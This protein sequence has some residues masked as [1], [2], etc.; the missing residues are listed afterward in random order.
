MPYTGGIY[1]AALEFTERHISESGDISLK[2]KSLVNL[3]NK[4]Q[5]RQG[6]HS[7]A[8]PDL[9]GLDSQPIWEG[10][11]FIE[12]NLH[13]QQSIRTNVST[14]Q[15][16]SLIEQLSFKKKYDW[17]CL[18]KCAPACITCFHEIA[19]WVVCAGWC[20]ISCAIP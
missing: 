12:G 17:K 8:P 16:Y 13:N 9:E 5:F 14:S 7:E 4:E 11:I 1:T 3:Y 2:I 10:E 6:G 19:C 18:A 20:V 15:D